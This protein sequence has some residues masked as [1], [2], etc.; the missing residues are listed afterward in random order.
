MRSISKQSSG[1]Y[2]LNQ[3]NANPPN[4]SHDATTRW[5]S[6]GHKRQ[7]LQ[8]LLDEQFQLCCYSELRADEEGLDYHIEHVENKSQ[9]PARTFDYSN[10]AA[11][12]LGSTNDLSAFKAQGDEVFG[13]HAAGKRQGCNMNRFVSCHHVN[14]QHFFSFLSDGRVGPNSSLNG[15]CR[16]H[17]QYTID[18][19][20][21]NSPYLVTRRRQWWDE[22]DDLYQ[23][24]VANGG[25]LFHLAAVHVV[26]TGNKL[27]RFFSLTR[28]FFGPHA[29]SAL[30]QQ[31]PGL[32]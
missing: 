13:G 9:N 27:Y 30:K 22:L 21:L 4:T 5:K 8:S 6:F 25:S 7:V 17:A 26:P 11:S 10:L 23:D 14:S 20:N 2:H 19:L 3:A 31:A 18:L 24:H 28:E 32:L 12:A 15:K 16:D 1:G 29:E